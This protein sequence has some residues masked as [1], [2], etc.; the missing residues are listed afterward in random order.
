ML[1]TFIVTYI[2]TQKGY[3]VHR[4]I[5]IRPEILARGERENNPFIL[6]VIKTNFSIIAASPGEGTRD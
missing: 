3:F 5:A 1:E 4:N 6:P 2:Q